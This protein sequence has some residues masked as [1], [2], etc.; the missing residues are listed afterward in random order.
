MTDLLHD[1]TLQ[2]GGDA[3]PGFSPPSLE[4]RHVYLRTLTVADYPGIRLAEGGGDLGV[5]WRFRGST[6]SPEQWVQSIWQAVLVQFLIVRRSDHEPI[7]IVVAYRPSFQDQH[8]YLGVAAFPSRKRSPLMMFGTALFIEYVFTCWNFRKLY[9]E[10]P[11]FNLSQFS[12]GLGRFLEQEGRMREHL[13]YAGRMWDQ[14]VLALYRD[15]WQRESRRVLAMASPEPV[16]RV[17]LP[18]LGDLTT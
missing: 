8:A 10:L 14:V 15:T 3:P 6:A 7:G 5:R 13:W 16:V 4:G 2:L 9:L 12:S 17:R 1:D 11:E 18:D